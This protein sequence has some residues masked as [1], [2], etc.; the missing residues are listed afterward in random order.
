M[1]G[2]RGRI[3][4]TRG[5]SPETPGRMPG[6]Q[7]KSPETQGRIPGK[8]GRMPGKRAKNPAERGRGPAEEESLSL[9]RALPSPERGSLSGKQP[10]SS[11]DGSSPSRTRPGASENGPRAHQNRAKPPV[12]TRP[13]FVTG[14]RTKVARGGSAPL[15]NEHPL[16]PLLSSRAHNLRSSKSIQMNLFSLIGAL[17]LPTPSINLSDHVL[18][19]LQLRTTRKVPDANT[20]RMI[21]HHP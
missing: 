17:F 6:K 15:E 20:Q 8:R 5:K 1:P 19:Q 13:V 16:F 9:T 7:A 10:G 2:K 12:I 21:R 11:P 3:P 4:A 14:G 18:H